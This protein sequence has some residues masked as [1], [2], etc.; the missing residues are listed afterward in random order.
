[1][2]A[3]A[4][5]MVLATTSFWMDNHKCFLPTAYVFES[6]HRFWDEADGIMKGIAQEPALK[7]RYRYR[8]H[9]AMDKTE[10]YGLQEA[11]S[12]GS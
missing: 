3:T 5:Q 8:T 9:F 11:C 12:R 4:C 2:Y 7:A 10:S 6:G 1:M